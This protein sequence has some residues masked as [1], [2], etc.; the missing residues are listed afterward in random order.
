MENTTEGWRVQMTAGVILLAMV[1]ATTLADIINNFLYGWAISGMAALVMV[2]AAF[3]VPAIPAVAQ[4][5]G[6]CPLKLA[7]AAAAVAMTIYSA[8]AAYSTGQAN[9]SL[10]SQTVNENYSKARLKETR[11]N[12]L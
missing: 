11:A 9:T 7:A 3:A 4:K 2:I 6:W 8:W 5:R 12:E 10:A 1:A